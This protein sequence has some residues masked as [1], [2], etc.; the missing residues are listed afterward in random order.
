MLTADRHDFGRKI[1]LKIL[2]A[3]KRIAECGFNEGERLLLSIR[4]PQSAIRNW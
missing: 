3:P 4:I 1:A 2:L